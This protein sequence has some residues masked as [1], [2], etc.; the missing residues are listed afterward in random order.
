MLT[1]EDRLTIHELL[2]RLDHAVDSQD[3][4][5]YVSFFAEDATL[6][7]GFAGTVQGQANIRAWLV[8]A[9]G[10]TK[11]KRHV[12]TNVVIDGDA[13]Q[14]TARSY[15]TVIEREDIPTVVA[16]A[17]ITD[18]LKKARDGWKV[19][20]HEVRIDPGMMKAFAAKSAAR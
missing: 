7:S 3:W 8:Q 1:F 20:R 17:L 10:S 15:L 4:D 9:E 16:T 6:D 5:T 14:A 2:A 12:A 19:T 18:T 11:G 13:T